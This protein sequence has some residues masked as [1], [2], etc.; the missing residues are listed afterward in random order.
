MCG[1]DIAL[2]AL[3]EM[4]TN[5]R[6][7]APD[8]GGASSKLAKPFSLPKIFAP[9]ALDELEKIEGSEWRAHQESHK[10]DPKTFYANLTPAAVVR[11]MTREAEKAVEAA[12]GDAKEQARKHLEAVE[13]IMV[14]H[15]VSGTGIIEGHFNDYVVANDG[16]LT[17]RRRK[18]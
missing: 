12:S 2:I 9:G 6:K 11:D 4:V 7:I 1:F 5:A 17:K 8:A 16:K 15:L 10:D 3:R 18:K 14:S 13:K